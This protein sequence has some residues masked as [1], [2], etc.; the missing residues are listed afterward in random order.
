ML[1]II[2]ILASVLNHMLMNSELPLS[3]KKELLDHLLNFV[4]DNKIKLFEKVI[5][6]RT[7]YLTVVLEDIYQ[8][9][10]ASAV[11]RTCDCF[12]IQD[13]HIIEN[14][15]KFDLNPDVAL[16]SAK[17]LT[18]HKYKNPEYSTLEVYRNLKE[19]GYR[20]IATTPHQN[21]CKLDNLKMDSKIALVFGTELN[22][23][24]EEAINHAD[25]FVK[26]P[27]VGF[28]ESFN[29]SVSA[30][31]ILHHL[32]EKLR[33]SEHHWQLEEQEV[34]DIKLSWL[35]NVVKSS[36]KIEERLFNKC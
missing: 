14:K 27:M 32:S 22:G 10:N 9:H 6:Y 26:I 31:I 33:S 24:S 15:N 34:I 23:L 7:R 12:G 20:I 5:Q 35:K 1:I 30:A 25:E 2:S 17:W 36:D 3:K 4:T 18:L 28:T 13:I 8:S 11:L 29:L 16:G 19:L 21:D